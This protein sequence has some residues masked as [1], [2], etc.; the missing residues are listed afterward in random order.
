[1]RRHES[2]SRPG[3]VGYGS[4]VGCGEAEGCRARAPYTLTTNG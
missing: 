3:I 1:M 4:G 2:F